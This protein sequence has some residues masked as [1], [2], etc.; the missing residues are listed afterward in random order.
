MCKYPNAQFTSTGNGRPIS[1][2]GTSTGSVKSH[3]QYCV[4]RSFSSFSGSGACSVMSGVTTLPSGQIYQ[5][6]ERS[7]SALFL[8]DHKKDHIGTGR[9]PY[10]KWDR[11]HRVQFRYGAQ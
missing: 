1:N 9:A 3:F 2:T 5:N 4:D 6:R 11:A 7:A 10:R 8:R